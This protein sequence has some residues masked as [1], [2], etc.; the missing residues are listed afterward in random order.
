MTM[1]LSEPSRAHR[2][3]KAP[4]KWFGGKSRVARDVWLRFRDVPNYV[5]PFF[6]SGAVL[7]GRECPGKTETV[8]DMDGFVCNAWRSIRDYPV[9]TATHSTNPVNECDKHARIAAIVAQRDDLVA[10]L[11]GDPEY[12]DP[13]IAGWW[14]WGLATWIGG[15]YCGE[16]GAWSVLDGRLVRQKSPQGISRQIP[17]ISGGRSGVNTKLLGNCGRN[18]FAPTEELIEW[19][20]T[21]AMRLRGVRICC[22]DWTRVVKPTATTQNGLTAVFLDPPYDEDERDPTVYACETRGVAAK[23]RQWCIENGSNPLLRIALCGY[24][25]EGHEVLEGLGWSVHAWSATGGY[26]NR[27]GS[28]NRHRERIWFSPACH[29]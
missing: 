14:L 9:E 20:D 6:G 10:R 25:G 23:V 27:T 18:P 17:Q 19:F 26:S 29:C 24:A 4:F 21:L 16:G 13:K 11:Q 28:Q 12:S 3:L 15:G 7:L 2:P 1:L 5:E 22:G 8:N